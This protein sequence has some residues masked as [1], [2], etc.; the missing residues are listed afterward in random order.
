[1]LLV[2]CHLQ[3]DQIQT[4]SFKHLGL[5]NLPLQHHLPT[6]SKSVS[7]ESI[8]AEQHW[9]PCFNPCR[10]SPLEEMLELLEPKGPSQCHALPLGPQ[11]IENKTS[12]QGK[13]ESKLP[14]LSLVKAKL[15]QQFSVSTS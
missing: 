14:S 2:G 10:S 9:R 12:L 13:W 4:L 1:M 8:C 11:P 5:G 7:A 15:E 3:I 6:N